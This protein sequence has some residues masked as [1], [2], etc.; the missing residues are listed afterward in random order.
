MYQQEESIRDLNRALEILEEAA[1]VG[2]D[3]SWNMLYAHQLLELYLDP[4]IG[5]QY[6]KVAALMKHGARELYRHRPYDLARLYLE[7]QYGILDWQEGVYWMYQAAAQGDRKA[8]AWFE[9]LGK[10]N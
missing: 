10:E 7:E 4:E 2:K 5:P 1:G 6:E 9:E 3:G 8:I